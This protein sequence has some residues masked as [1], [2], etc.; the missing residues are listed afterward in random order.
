MNGFLKRLLQLNFLLCTFIVLEAAHKPWTFLVY[1]AAANDLNQFVDV[2]LQEL[3]K[4][5]SNG[6][7]N[8]IVYLT[9]HEEGKQKT[10][11]KLYIAQNSI[12]QITDSLPRDSGDIATLEEALQWACLDYPSNHLA[13]VVWSKGS[14]VLNRSGSCVTKGVCYDCDTDHYL[15]DRDCAQAF[16]WARDILKK[17]KKIDI[18][19]FDASLLSSLE[20]AYSLSSS[21]DYMV[22]SEAAVNDGYRYAYILGQLTSKALDPLSFAELMATSGNDNSIGNTNYTLSVTDLNALEPLVNN[23]NAIAQIL[24]SQL[25]GKNKAA[26][27]ATIK[28]CINH[29][30]C[31]SFDEGIYIDLYQ[32]YKNLLNNIGGLK[33]SLSL[34]NQFKAVLNNGIKLFDTIIKAHNTS[35]HYKQTGGLSIY[36]SR[37]SIDPSYYGLYW[38][39]Q[40]PNWL[41]FLEAFIA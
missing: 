9:L 35:I 27:K 10:T 28:K 17:G 24:T 23:C 26:V 34:S 16:L 14:G 38:T 21:I 6:M 15:T 41:N 33:L 40:N 19:A 25:T 22:A 39:E 11:K 20:M 1:M 30:H 13:V 12:V 37:H 3:M 18:V 2:H 32:F 4:V 31:L 36:F 29:K 5:G 7:V 8:V